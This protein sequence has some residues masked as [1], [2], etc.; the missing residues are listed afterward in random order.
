MD[1]TETQSN[2]LL[3]NPKYFE[4]NSLIR[5]SNSKIILEMLNDFNNSKSFQDVVDSLIKNAIKIVSL[6]KAIILSTTKDSKLELQAAVNN[7]G[8][9]LDLKEIDFD[10]EI[11]K[12]VFYK[13][14]TVIAEN[15][16]KNKQLRKDGFIFSTELEFIYCSP[17]LINKK[18]VLVLYIE[19]KSINKNRV[20]EIKELLEILTLQGNNALRNLKLVEN[21]NKILAQLNESNQLLAEANSKI[22]E[23]QKLKDEFLAQ[24]SHEIRTPLNIIINYN[25]LI[26]EEVKNYISKDTELYFN[27]IEIDSKRLIRTIDSILNMA[28]LKSGKCSLFFENINAYQD[29]IYPV[30]SEFRI[31]LEDKKLNL[32]IEDKSINKNI[33][34]DKYSVIQII[35][36]LIDNAI[37]FTEA[38]YIK[39]SL[40]NE[41]GYLCV[42]V[43]DTGKGISEEYMKNLFRPFSQEEH[44]FARGHDGNGLGLALVK[45][46]IELNQGT[47]H[48]E[49]NKGFGSIF[50]VKFRT[51]KPE[52]TAQ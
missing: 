23:S 1:Y 11:I 30:L 38:G 19:S 43:K 33:Y 25:D 18:V 46:F 39:V 36:N 12:E 35:N 47:L 9:R 51:T 17:L 24:M 8:E 44:G 3:K 13:A 4:L 32:F 41:D 20:D 37:K 42:T 7:L 48:I 10:S 29:I 40:Y 52:E 2:V 50:T 21:R 28:Q 49:S 16:K 26:K 34:A 5:E 14:E 27:A 15:P 45:Q 31:E 6:E 22:E